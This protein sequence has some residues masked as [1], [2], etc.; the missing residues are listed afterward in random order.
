MCMYFSF[1]VQLNV[2][3]D[4]YLYGIRPFLLV[5]VAAC[6]PEISTALEDSVTLLLGVPPSLLARVGGAG[7]L[8]GVIRGGWVTTKGAGEDSSVEDVTGSDAI[9]MNW[10]NGPAVATSDTSPGTRGAGVIGE[11]REGVSG[12]T[13]LPDATCIAS[14]SK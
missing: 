6:A 11:G 5:V 14:E 1:V 12:M 10:V 2:G 8:I 9:A 4:A 3:W 13:P 7:A